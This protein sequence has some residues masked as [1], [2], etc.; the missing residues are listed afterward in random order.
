[1]RLLRSAQYVLVTV[2]Y[3]LEKRERG[4]PWP[5]RN[6]RVSASE[7]TNARRIQAVVSETFPRV[8]FGRPPAITHRA[9][10]RFS[11][12]RDLIRHIT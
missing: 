3:A 9:P 8:P 5:Q 1:M 7:R 10:V 2:H 12:A 4:S 11:R 6:S